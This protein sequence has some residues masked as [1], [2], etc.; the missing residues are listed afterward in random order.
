[1]EKRSPVLASSG[2]RDVS[3]CTLEPDSP[4]REEESLPLSPSS[5]PHSKSALAKE[6]LHTLLSS[7]PSLRS[8]GGLL[9]D[10]LQRSTLRIGLLHQEP[11]ACLKGPLSNL[12]QPSTR[13]RK[14]ARD[15]LPLPFYPVQ[16]ARQTRRESRDAPA[17]TVALS[18]DEQIWLRPCGHRLEAPVLFARA[19]PAL[20]GVA[21][22]VSQE[23]TRS[24]AAPSR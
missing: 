3:L 4:G 18:E 5:L 24:D 1:M 17:E 16:A 15:L 22:T 2:S 9:A 8:A 20:A 7:E 19:L 21:G 10:L 14:V 13:R 23:P 11:T 6:L 12:T